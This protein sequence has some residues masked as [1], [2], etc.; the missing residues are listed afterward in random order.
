MLRMAVIGVG[1]MGSRYA[2]LLQDGK[3]AGAELVALT[4]VKDKYR[5]CLKKTLE[6]GIP[7]YET[8]DLLFEAAESGK[9]QFDCVVIATPHYSHESLAVRAFQNGI[10]VL[11]DKP[12]G[13]YSRQA[14]NMDEAA[15]SSGKVFSMVFNQRTYPIYVKLREIVKSGEYGALKRVSWTITDWYR[16]D[17]YYRSSVWRATWEKEGGGVLLNQ[18]PHN[19]DML[20]WIC[21]L[22][23]RVQAFCHEGRFH[24]IEVE[25][26][27]TAY[28]EWDNGATGTFVTS[29]G[30]APGINRL[31]IA[32]E[33]ALII[34]ENDELRIGSISEELGMKEADYR[35]ASQES[36]RKIKGTW[37]ESS[38]EKEP[39]Q[40]I[41]ILQAFADECNGRGKSIAAGREGRYSLLLSNAMYLSSWEGKMIEIPVPGS[42]NEQEFEKCFEEGLH[43]KVAKAVVN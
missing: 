40:Y 11:C 42:E 8:A 24:N 12:A 10:N 28:L 30:D 29:T 18:A 39:D 27:V 20:C 2:A 16:P 13:V 9:R 7:V 6:S 31:E 32:L 41:K 26:D 43:R 1:N 15:V 5:E 35:K 4:R 25:D 17:S 37:S 14:R 33:E 3:I 34:C 38:F 22:P 23:A 36:F 21:G 19:L